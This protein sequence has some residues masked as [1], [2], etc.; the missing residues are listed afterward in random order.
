MSGTITSPPGITCGNHPDTP[1]EVKHLTVE[2]VRRCHLD[3]EVFG[4][5]WLIERTDEV[6]DDEFGWEPYTRIVACGAVAWPTPR[7]WEC[8]AGHDYVD[9]ETRRR[10]NWDY[11]HDEQE[12]AGMRKRGVGAVAMNGGHI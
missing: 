5:G 7:G 6:G 12:A 2:G 10:E 11:A 9:I 8:E 4:C 1:D 3:L